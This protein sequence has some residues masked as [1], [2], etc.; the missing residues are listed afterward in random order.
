[1]TRV[2]W[3]TGAG[4]GLG[5]QVSLQL[6]EAGW[7]VAATSRT[8]EDLNSL[9]ADAQHFVG[10]VHPFQADI[11]DRDAIA[12]LVEKIE[13]EIGPLDLAILN[14]GT[15][16]R[17]GLEDF[18]AE[19]FAHQME[20]NVMNGKLSQPLAEKDEKP[21]PGA[22]CRCILVKRPPRPSHGI[23]LWS[24]KG[25]NNQYVRSS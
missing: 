10:S 14:A 2:V 20:I 21:S 25:R 6:A 5:R 9:A 15:Y 16:L 12:G 24:V 17:F 19:R 3:V 4:K 22:D 18:S 13:D 8:A 1:M 23:C 7:R 11:I